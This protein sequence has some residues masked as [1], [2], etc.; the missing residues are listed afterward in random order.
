MFARPPVRDVKDEYPDADAEE[1]PV[2]RWMWHHRLI[3]SRA[4][5]IVIWSENKGEGEGASLDEG[6]GEGREKREG[7]EVG[8]VEGAEGGFHGGWVNGRGRGGREWDLFVEEG[9]YVAENQIRNRSELIMHVD[10]FWRRVDNLSKVFALCGN[11]CR[12]LFF[13]THT[14]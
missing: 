13:Y 6:G 2:L 4:K 14:S 7:E 5:R 10:H 12:F 11:S 9:V 1:L 3:G 8:G